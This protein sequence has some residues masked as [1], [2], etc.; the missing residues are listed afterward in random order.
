MLLQLRRSKG[1]SYELC[2]EAVSVHSLM[3][4][5]CQFANPAFFDSQIES[6]VFYW[7]ATPVDFKEL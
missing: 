3:V 2:C 7:S 4:K 1:I 5:P 6:R